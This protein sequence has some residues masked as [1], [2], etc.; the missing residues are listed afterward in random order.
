MSRIKIKNFGPIKE[1]YQEN[2]GWMDVKKVTVFIGNQGSGKSTVAKLISTMS[3]IEK[4]YNRGDLTSSKF[5]VALFLSFLKFHRINNYYRNDK[6]IVEFEG[7]SYNISYNYNNKYPI[8]RKSDHKHYIVPKIMYVPAER[9][10]LSSVSDAFKRTGLPESLFTFAEELRKAQNELNGEKLKL[11]IGDYT[12]EYDENQDNSFVTG[13]NYRIN[14]VEAS[15]GLQ[16]FIPLYLVSK[17]LSSSIFENQEN[18]TRNLTVEQSVRLA[19]EILDLT[20]DKSLKVSERNKKIAEVKA[21]YFNKCF[22]NIVEEPEQNLFPTS[23][24]QMLKSLL[25]FNNMNEGN[26]LI[27]TT[28]SPYLINYLTLVVKA[29]KVYQLLKAKNF[30]L[31]DPEVMQVNEIVSMSSLIKSN[32]LVIYEL[33]EQNGSI[34]ALG[35]FEGIPSDMNFLNKSLGNINQLYDSLLEIEENL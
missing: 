18:L 28:H 21:R 1:G 22:I 24:K 8:I 3:W 4:A 12:Y 16:S 9:N 10:F 32:D 35:N 33:D 30:K 27:M 29:E 26:K 17:N 15:S 20:Y 34:K 2:D 31:G 19:N 25:E 7:D 23:Q 6:T 14:L 5:H 13:L 11:P